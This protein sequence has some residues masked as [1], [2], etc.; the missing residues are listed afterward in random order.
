MMSWGK[1]IA[2]FIVFFCFVVIAMV[3][4][5]M[6]QTNE[7][8]DKNY[9]AK[10]LLYQN[11]ID[12]KNNLAASPNQLVFRENADSFIVQFPST[13]VTDISENS[14]YLLCPSDESKDYVAAFKLND[15]QEHVILKKQLAKVYYTI[16][17][18]WKNAGKPYYFERSQFIN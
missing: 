6:Q 5:A 10:E 3:Y 17:I 12:G 9:Y 4:V 2:V 13:L 1:G 7:M 18:S 16:K 14:I 11:V 8:Q 15:K